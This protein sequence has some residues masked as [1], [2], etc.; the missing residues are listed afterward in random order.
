MWASA[1]NCEPFALPNQ[2][3]SESTGTAARSPTVCTP[4]DPRRSSVA[5]PT[6]QMRR[7]GSGHRKSSS[8]P[9]GTAR[10]PSGFAA[11]LAT[12]ARNFVEATPMLSGRPTSSRIRSRNRAAMWLGPPWVRSRPLTSRNA[13]SMDRPSTSGV[14]SRNTAKTSALAWEY[15]FIR[16]GTTTAS[17][18][19]RRASVL[20]M[21]VRTPLARAS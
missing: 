11:A 3:R 6:P 9:S 16:G 19:N 7:T 12:L 2:L 8:P 1:C 18:H 4:R 20:F 10:S 13:S 15:A 17:G 5:G 14:V 21:A